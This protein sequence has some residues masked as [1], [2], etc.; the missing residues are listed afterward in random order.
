M[1]KLKQRHSKSKPVI[2]VVDQKIIDFA[3]VECSLFFPYHKK[4]LTMTNAACIS[5]SGGV[6]KDGSAT[7]GLSGLVFEGERYFLLKITF[8][9]LVL[10]N[11]KLEKNPAFGTS[12]N[13]SRCAD[14]NNNTMEK[15]EE[16]RKTKKNSRFF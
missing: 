12:L 13:L 16:P 2:T 8:G 14:K 10:N 15:K 1:L 3:C 11:K 7:N 9:C 6:S 4:R 5:I